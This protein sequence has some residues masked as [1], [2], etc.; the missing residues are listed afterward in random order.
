MTANRIVE[1]ILDKPNLPD[2]LN[3]LAN[4]SKAGGACRNTIDLVAAQAASPVEAFRE[5]ARALESLLAR[6]YATDW[7]RRRRDFT[8]VE[9][10]AEKHS[11][12]SGFIEEY[13]LDPIYDSEVKAS[14]VDAVTLITVHSAKG[15]EAKVCYV[16]NASPGSYPSEKSMS[17]I[18]DIEEERRVLYVALTRAK[19]EL[20]VSRR[21]YTTHAVNPSVSP[22]EQDAATAY[23]LNNLPADLVD[24]EIIAPQGW[25]SNP[26]SGQLPVTGTMP[27]IGIIFD[28]EEE[29]AEP[30]VAE[31]MSPKADH[32]DTN[33]STADNDLAELWLKLLEAV[34]QVSSYA[35]VFLFDGHPVS[36]ANGVF[37][38]G[39]SPSYGKR[40]SITDNTRD[41]LIVTKLAELGHPNV[42]IR[43][44]STGITKAISSQPT[45]PN[46]NKSPIDANL[47]ELWLKLVEAVG[48]VSPFTRS[49]LVNAH[50]VSF[51]NNV[52]T[53]GFAPEYKE[54]AKLLDNARNH[55]L[56]TNKLTEL[57][58]PNAMIKFIKAE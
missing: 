34:G 19:D 12:I 35:R 46:E 25:Q 44:I 52:F 45:K 54:H 40:A 29:N 42:A 20:I 57:S 16:I 22:D 14:S 9:K 58:H 13:I 30:F 4:D 37:T 31:K 21:S 33:P 36:L 39:F 48:F 47:A 15:T 55:I 41:K 11:T 2:I 43:F 5:S 3:T 23:F 6:R 7:D 17:D 49:Y 56:L 26:K 51:E 50:P 24:E 28:S 38:V 1:R 18:E 8:L 53:I 10:L 27:K 32:T